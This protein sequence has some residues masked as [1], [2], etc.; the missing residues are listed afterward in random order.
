MT[1]AS[2]T[3]PCALHGN[4][5]GLRVPESVSGRIIEASEGNKGPVLE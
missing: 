1:L 4:P 5:T 2:G 3:A